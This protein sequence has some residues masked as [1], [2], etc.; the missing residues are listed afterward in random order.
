MCHLGAKSPFGDRSAWLTLFTTWDHWALGFKGQDGGHEA[1]YRT[2]LEKNRQEE[3][4]TVVHKAQQR[5]EDMKQL[6]F[7]CQRSKNI[8]KPGVLCHLVANSY[9]LSPVH[10]ELGDGSTV[11]WEECK[12]QQILKSAH[13]PHWSSFY[14]L[15]QHRDQMHLRRSLFCH[16]A[17]PKAEITPCDDKRVMLQSVACH[18]SFCTAS[19]IW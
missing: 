2:Q 4:K 8:I 16:L 17:L 13:G 11:A 9:T 10:C 6:E 18:W 19:Q 1:F 5:W 15:V 3:L 14:T 12:V 7:T